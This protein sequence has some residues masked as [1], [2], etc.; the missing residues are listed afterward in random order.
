[1]PQEIHGFVL[2]DDHDTYYCGMIIIIQQ[3]MDITWILLWNYEI[4]VGNL[5]DSGFHD[6]SGDLLMIDIF[7][8]NMGEYGRYT[9]TLDLSPNFCVSHGAMAEALPSWWW[10]SR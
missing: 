6:A 9:E 7:W 2:K 10:W 4:E 8:E 5:W 3:S 1:M